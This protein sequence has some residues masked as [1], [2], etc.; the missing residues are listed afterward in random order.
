MPSKARKVLKTLANRAST[1]RRRAKAAA[2]S[3]GPG[4]VNALQP[5]HAELLLR[6]LEQ[7]TSPFHEQN[8]VACVRSFAAER[9][10]NVLQD[11]A[12]NLAIDLP[13]QQASADSKSAES[14][15]PARLAR[16]AKPTK[17]TKPAKSADEASPRV[18]YLA[19]MDHPG[20][21][22]LTPARRGVL[23]A[24]WMGGVPND[25]LIGAPVRYYARGEGSEML[26]GWPGAGSSFALGGAG[27]AGRITKII[28]SDA[29]G[30]AER[31]RVELAD[32]ATRVAA[33]DLG[34]F[35]FGPP[36]R[37]D[38]FIHATAID[39]L[40]SC[41][42]LLCLLDLLHRTGT[43]T[44]LRA[45]FTR[46]EEGGFFGLCEAAGARRIHGA[47]PAGSRTA[48]SSL[49]GPDDVCIVLE[50]SKRLAHAAQGNGPIVRV[51][52]RLAMFAPQVT[53]LLCQSAEQLQDTRPGFAWQRQLMDGG[54][55][56]AAVL[57]ALGL[58]VGGVCCPLGNYHN[59][60]EASPGLAQEFIHEHDAA[61]LID[62]L[63][64]AL[65]ALHDFARKP[66]THRPAWLDRVFEH[67]DQVIPCFTDPAAG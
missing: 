16:S 23:T 36:R 66:E 65:P 8:V 62:L 26:S 33:G 11:D 24:R 51:G 17:P 2:P 47:R 45:V 13:A 39:N 41:G 48:K 67:F 1:A 43:S 31:V 25:R 18:V 49:I 19:H 30:R 64:G 10:L 44:P 37:E 4:S 42:V 35:D 12:G 7:P 52:D 40:A 57:C 34:Q 21:W 28:R 56:E 29:R 20:L 9:G 58:R 38:G 22:A 53:H 3:A 5:E 54:A 15:K 50:M 55:C 27:Q 61:R 63:A 59:I 6:V 46:A 14:A 60:D 32:T